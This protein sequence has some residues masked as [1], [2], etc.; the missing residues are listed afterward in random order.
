[1]TLGK[2]IDIDF[3]NKCFKEIQYTPNWANY[4]DWQVYDVCL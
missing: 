2:K 3:G 1:M 4:K